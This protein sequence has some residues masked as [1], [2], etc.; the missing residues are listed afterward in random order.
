MQTAL[1][2]KAEIANPTFTSTVNGITKAMVG[3]ISID[4]A[5]DASK[6]IST[7]AQGSL[8]LKASSADVDRKF[9]SLLKGAPDALNTLTGV[10]TAIGSDPNYSTT[11]LTALN[12]E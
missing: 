1:D 8:D 10:A 12:G 2:L 6:P 9:T 7:A 5:S 11:L 3:L 4:N